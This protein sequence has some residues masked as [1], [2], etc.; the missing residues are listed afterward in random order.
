MTMP[1]IAYGK[2]KPLRQ[3]KGLN[4]ADIAAELGISRPTYVLIE[5]GAK[6]PTLTQ[7]YTLSRLLGVEPGEL[8]SNL[9]FIASG[10]IN[11]DK[12][13]ELVAVC[14]A[15]GSNA[16]AITKSKLSVLVYLH[17]FAWYNLYS[18]PM[19]G[20]IYRCTPR[21]P[22]ADDFL[23]VLD[24]LYEAQAVA[25]EPAGATLIVRPIELPK[26]RLLNSDELALATE[27]CNK[28]RQE[29]TEAAIDFAIQQP[30]CRAVKTGDPI[31]YEA[32]QGEPKSSLY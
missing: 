17:D 3:A 27:I 11:Y 19:T 5:Q 13:K 32:I 9:P 14:A 1:I 25:L 4:Q 29:S 24:E 6:E 2:I 10:N 7:L 28:W 18:R 23:R 12:F 30:P 20:E 31:P 21:G 22:I 8:C 26:P 15:A 16:G